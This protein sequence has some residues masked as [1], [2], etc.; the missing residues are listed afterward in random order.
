MF[1]VLFAHVV[2]Y[3]RFIARTRSHSDNMSTKIYVSHAETAV[4]MLQ[5]HSLRSV[6]DTATYW[7]LAKG[8]IAVAVPCWRLARCVVAAYL[9]DPQ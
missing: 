8:N 7:R 4:L 3:Q 9:I 5:R 2:N 6:L 1:V